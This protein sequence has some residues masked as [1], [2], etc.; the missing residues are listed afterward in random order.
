MRR[1]QHAEAFAL[2]EGAH[3]ADDALARADVEADGR[4]VEQQQ[5][6]PVQ[7][8]ARDLDAAGLAAGQVA[9]LLPGAVGEADDLERALRA[10]A[11]FAAADAVQR[12]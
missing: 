12:A 6:R 10:L 2:H 7:Q 9:H 8:R 4:L 1:P 5:R 3:D 11:R